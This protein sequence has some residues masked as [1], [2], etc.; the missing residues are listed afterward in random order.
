[1][2]REPH[3]ERA[4]SNVREF[5][6][7]LLLAALLLIPFSSA[8]KAE[9]SAHVDDING[10]RRQASQLSQAGKFAEAVPLSQ[11]ALAR[12][13][14]QFAATHPEVAAA[15]NDLANLYL[16]QERYLDAETHYKR[17]LAIYDAVPGYA[18]GELW[19]V[20]SRLETLYAAQGRWSDAEPLV[21]RARWIER[22]VSAPFGVDIKAREIVTTDLKR[23][24]LT[25]CGAVWFGV[26]DARDYLVQLGNAELAQSYSSGIIAAAFRKALANKA[27]AQIRDQAEAILPEIRLLIDAN[28]RHTGVFVREIKADLKGCMTPA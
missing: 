2:L 22:K 17:V 16:A 10:L 4:V 14:E 11:R 15:L 23:L 5:A 25:N 20:L 1:M 28:T 12:A 13:E 7:A 6:S 3:Q 21:L 24:R 8:L 9:Q 18:D 27:A 26:S 19:N